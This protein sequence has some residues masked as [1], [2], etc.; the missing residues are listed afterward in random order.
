MGEQDKATKKIFSKKKKSLIA[1][2]LL[3]LLV[4]ALVI[5]SIRNLKSP[6]VGSIQQS[7]T[8][9]AEKTIPF[10]QPGSYKGKYVSFTYPAHFKAEP[11]RLT[12]SYLE[13]ADYGSTDQTSKHI[14]VGVSKS[15]INSDGGVSFR[16]LRPELYKEISSSRGVEFTKIDGTEDTFF[17]EHNGLLASVSTTA[18]SASLNGETTF[19]SSSLKWR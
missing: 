19:V 10:S 4:V 7:P 11:T 15:S 16:R 8:T 18:P 1:A 3:M 12:G 6:A 2:V 9:Q 17:M 14:N 5:L 13:T